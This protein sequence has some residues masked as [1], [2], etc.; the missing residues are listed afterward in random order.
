MYKRKMGR[1][2]YYFHKDSGLEID[3]LMRY[4]GECVLVECKVRT[5]NAKST[6]TILN[7]Q[8]KYHVKHAIKIGDYNVGR[9]GALLTIPYLY[10][11]S[12]DGDM[13]EKRKLIYRIRRRLLHLRLQPIRV[14][15]FHQVSDEFDPS[16]MW[17][18]DWTQT[19]Q[20]KR[21]ILQ[22]KAEYT[23]IALDNAHK[24]LVSDKFRIRKYAVLTCDDGWASIKDIIPWLVEQ[25]I[26]ITLFINPLYLDGKHFQ[27][28]STE[29]LLTKNNLEVLIS[30]YPHHITVASHG[31]THID[32]ST[33]SLDDFISNVK[34]AEKELVNF[35]NKINF[36]AFT[37]GHHK[38]EQ[39]MF[40]AGQNI[41][42]VLIDGEKNYNFDG[43]IHRESLEKKIS[44]YV[45]IFIFNTNL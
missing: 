10:G 35:A 3:F 40:L 9:D 42:P 21:N 14:F 25:D 7:H 5:G 27:L 29:K 26:P 33:L 43:R 24:H 32:A 23:F 38:N 2:L 19:E 16:T 22:L 15:C 44:T 28:R 1:K 45:E 31:F 13:I 11:F 4:K 20:F 34:E 41:V 12:I 37:Y 39:M 8:E 36:Y 18:C 6:R 17:E 30:K